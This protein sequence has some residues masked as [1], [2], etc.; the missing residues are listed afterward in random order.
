MSAEEVG[1]DVATFYAY[2]IRTHNIEDIP[3]E[4]I[5]DVFALYIFRYLE[6]TDKMFDEN[7][8]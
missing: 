1:E 5:N 7:L 8:N 4:D 2:Y 3:M 6:Y